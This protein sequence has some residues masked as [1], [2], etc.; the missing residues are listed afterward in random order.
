[1]LRLLG[2]LRGLRVQLLLWLVLPLTLVLVAVAITGISVH[3]DLMRQIIEELDARSA[4][5]AANRLSDRLTERVT[6]LKATAANP[7]LAFDDT[8]DLYF[9]GGLARYNAAGQLVDASPSLNAW[10]ARPV[11]ES[12]NLVSRPELRS[13][14]GQDQPD[15]MF[16]S[17]PGRPALGPGELAHRSGFRQ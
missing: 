15:R 12:L 2:S 13:R 17:P 10:R 5:L 7:G 8:S 6:W 4:L 11:F 14:A 1:M 3:Q 9:D 16:F